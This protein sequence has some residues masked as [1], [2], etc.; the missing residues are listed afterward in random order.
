MTVLA[1]LPRRRPVRAIWAKTAV[2]V[3]QERADQ[4]EP[5]DEAL[6]HHRQLPFSFE[7]NVPAS[8]Q[9]LGAERLK[10]SSA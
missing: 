9:K 4:R 2:C 8:R 10:N 5:D 3:E 7:R 1:A 6:E